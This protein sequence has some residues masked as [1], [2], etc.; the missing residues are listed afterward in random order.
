MTRTRLSE[1]DLHLFREGTHTSLFEHLG[2]HLMSFDEEA[3]AYFAV[4]APQAREVYVAGDFDSWGGTAYP[5]EARE[6]S[7]IWEGFVPRAVAGQ[8]YKFRIVA[9]DGAVFW[10]ADPFARQQETL[11]GTASRLCQS[12]HQWTDQPWM[13][14]RTN[15]DWL[16][17]AVSVYEVH[18]G[19]WRRGLSYRELAPQLAAYVKELGFT[20]VEFLPVM[21][22]PFYG[23]WGYQTTGY[24]APTSRYGTPDDFRFL[25]DTL[26]AH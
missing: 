9:Q 19:S 18:L 8:L 14:A 17:S 2:G 23:S 21:E 20:H 16:S 5:L 11:P 15:R 4:W 12:T 1:F 7:G 10:K 6:T 13:E 22:H 24:F 25:I 3:G 26:H